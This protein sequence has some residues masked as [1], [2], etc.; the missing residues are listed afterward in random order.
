MPR[1]RRDWLMIC[2]NEAIKSKDIAGHQSE[3]IRTRM[4]VA[5]IA[6]RL[7]YHDAELADV[8]DQV[9]EIPKQ[10]GFPDNWASR[11]NDPF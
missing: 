9:A 10:T 4:R 6:H 3:D 7:R 11:D 1:N 5:A 2:C 8:L